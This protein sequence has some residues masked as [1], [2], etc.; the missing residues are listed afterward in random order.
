[1]IVT[2]HTHGWDQVEGLMSKAESRQPKIKKE[3]DNA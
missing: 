3:N 2:T 1:M